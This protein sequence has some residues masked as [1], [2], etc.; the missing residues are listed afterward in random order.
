VCSS[1]LAKAITSFGFASPAATGTINEAAKAIA[2]TV[3]YGTNPA[4][5]VA[6]FVTT[7]KSVVIGSTAQV[8]GTTPNNFTN[9]VVYTVTAEDNSTTTYTVTVTVALNSTKALTA[10]SLAGVAGVINESAKTILVSMPYGTNVNGLV[11]TF[12]TT[13]A[14]V[15]IGTTTQQTGIT[16]NNFPS[17]VGYKVT[18]V[19][20]SS[21]TYTVTATV[22]TLVS[23]AITPTGPNMGIGRT[24]Q[25]FAQ[26]LFSDSVTRDLTSSATWTSS[27]P[28]VATVSDVSGTK[29]IVSSIAVGTTTIMATDP[30]SSISGNTTLTVAVLQQ[31]GGAMIGGCLTLSADVSTIAGQAPFQG[32]INGAGLS[33]QFYDTIGVTTDGINLYVADKQN[34]AIRQI[35]IATGM[36]STLANVLMPYGITTDGTYLYVTTPINNTISQVVISS[37][38]VSTLTGSAGVAGSTDGTGTAALFYAPFGITTDGVNLYVSDY[39]NYTIRKIVISSGVVSTLTGSAGVPGSADGAG[40]A[41]LFYQPSG[42][43]TDGTNLYV[44]DAG[45]CTIRK[46]VIS[47]ADVTTFAG[48][49]SSCGVTDGIG[50][51]VQFGSLKGITTDGCSLYVADSND[52]R[53]V[54]IS[55]KEVKILAG[56]WS[57]SGYTDGIGRAASFSNPTG[58]TSDGTNMYIADTNNN[59]IRKME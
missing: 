11:A 51:V 53:Q 1:D 42:I 52:I 28:S 27:T 32:Y 20:G 29:G 55:T 30:V 35:V 14:L 48:T 26:G 16:T 40:S 46:I 41:A 37:G 2:V 13:G 23:I 9:P 7:G 39:N 36:V 12:T 43:A 18:A 54:V 44:N 21:V 45:N 3:P 49:A 50:A 58:L 19:D 4:A 22:P 47:T 15:T 31:Q 17:P 33:A 5:L 38:V 57:W 34:S 25:L 8:S 6:T 59:T 56:Y 24:K 10:F